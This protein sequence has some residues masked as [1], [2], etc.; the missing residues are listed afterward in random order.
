MKKLIY[1]CCAMVAGFAAT[2]QDL[3]FSQFYELPMMRNPALAGQFDCNF[4]VK[5]VYRNQWQ[6]V[7]VP[8]RTAGLS[9][10]IKLPTNRGNWHNFGLQV[11]YDVAGDS[12]LQRTHILPGYTFHLQL[13]ED[14]FLSMGFM[15]G[16][17]SS[18]FDATKLKWDDQY[19]NGQY[20]ASNPT[21]QVLRQTSI[22]YFDLAAGV[23]FNR[24]LGELGNLYV[25]GS[26]YHI[27]KPRVNFDAGD[28]NRLAHR[29]G[30]NAG[31]T[32]PAMEGSNNA[33]TFYADYFLQGGA[34]QFMAGGF[35]TF[36]LG[37]SYY[38]EM[39]KTNLHIGAVYRWNDAI[40]PAIKLDYQ[41]FSVGMSYDVNISKL[42][43]A[44]QARGGFEFTLSYRN[45]NI[46][47]NRSNGL[48]CP[49]FGNMF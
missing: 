44:S 21:S 14:N 16:Q 15:A 36:G 22:N 31:L 11:L 6:S 13:A 23:A 43:T 34:R 39:N 37:E 10:E 47:S 35:Y 8:F 7:T 42:K 17:V 41:M 45:C 32:V 30:L 38:D 29:F 26:M 12:R 27:N 1:I 9:A 5:S 20:S 49:K 24:P 40:I 4:R 19:V 28:T 18:Q 46:G 33:V 48:P 25:G 2:A 3:N